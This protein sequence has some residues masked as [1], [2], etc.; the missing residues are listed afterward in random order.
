M[1]RRP[2]AVAGTLTI[3]GVPGEGP[4]GSIPL[5]KVLRAP[6]AQGHELVVVKVIDKASPG[7]RN[8]AAGGKVF[9]TVI[10]EHQGQKITLKNVMVSS[11]KAQ[12]G[13]VGEFPL[14]EVRFTYQTIAWQYAPQD[15][16]QAT[17]KPSPSSQPYSTRAKP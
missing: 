9:P 1:A 6:S 4:G 10:L 12:R 16:D 5:Q 14:E 2:A 8:A 7:L 3:A 13:G 15:K 17:G 11:V